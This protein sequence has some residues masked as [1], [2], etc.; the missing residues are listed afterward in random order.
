MINILILGDAHIPDRAKELPLLIKERILEIKKHLPSKNFD[1]VVY[2]GDFVNSDPLYDFLS[3]LSLNFPADFHIVQGNMDRFYSGGKIKEL[4][5]PSDD[6]FLIMDKKIGIGVIHGHQ[7]R[8]RGN[9]DQ[10]YEICKQMECNILCSG[11]THA[12]SIDFIKPDVLLLNPGSIVGAWS[13]ISSNL[14]SFIHLS[15]T[16]N[17]EISV[18]V[19]ILRDNRVI[20][21]YHSFSIK[22]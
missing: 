2:T 6:K 9:L 17:L 1:H 21:E 10:L 20:K 18:I 19:H 15:I 4:N 11:H 14:P 8:P 7:V 16:K 13:F 3:T 5:V 12:H 22:E